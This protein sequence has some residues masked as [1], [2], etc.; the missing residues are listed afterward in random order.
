MTAGDVDQLGGAGADDGRQD[1]VFSCWSQA[2]LEHCVV[3][4]PRASSLARGPA[5]VSGVRR[6]RTGIPGGRC[7]G[8]VSAVPSRFRVS[9]GRDASSGNSF[10]HR[11]VLIGRKWQ[12]R[13]AGRHAPYAVA[14]R[15]AAGNRRDHV[16]AVDEKGCSLRFGGISIDL[17]SVRGRRRAREPALSRAELRSVVPARPTA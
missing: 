16:D 2:S 6:P 17:Q 13:L 5:L 10:G 11:E 14:G 7:A 12:T 1:G 8:F 3:S 9:R 15:E 4:A